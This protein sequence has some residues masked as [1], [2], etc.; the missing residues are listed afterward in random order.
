MLPLRPGP[1]RI[2]VGLLLRDTVMPVLVAEVPVPRL[3]ALGEG[4]DMGVATAMLIPEAVVPAETLTDVGLVAPLVPGLAMLV[5][6]EGVE[7]PPQPSSMKVRNKK[8]SANLTSS[9]PVGDSM[10]GRRLEVAGA[11]RSTGRMGSGLPL[12]CALIARLGRVGNGSVCEIP[13]S[14]PRPVTLL[15]KLG[16]CRSTF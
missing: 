9:S 16:D 2:M 12:A 13:S 7:P 14:R 15:F 6:V 4:L 8:R 3:S 5:G 11:V 1:N 10:L